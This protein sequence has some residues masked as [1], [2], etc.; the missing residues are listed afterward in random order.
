LGDLVEEV[1]AE[2]SAEAVAS[3]ERRL[4][5]VSC[6]DRVDAL[7]KV[8]RVY[9]RVTGQGVDALYSNVWVG[10]EVLGGRRLANQVPGDVRVHPIDFDR[11]EEAMGGSWDLLLT[12][13]SVQMRANDVGRLVETVRGGGLVVMAIPPVE[14]WLRTLTDFQRRLASPPYRESDVRN[15]FKRRFLET[16]RRAE[17]ARFVDLSSGSVEGRPRGAV[18]RELERPE[19][20][21][22]VLA[23]ALTPEQVEVVKAIDRL[24]RVSGRAALLVVANRGRG[25]SAALGLGIA[26]LMARRGVRGVA[27]TAPTLPTVQT[28]FKFVSRGLEALGIRGREV[29]RDGEVVAVTARGRSAFYLTPLSLVDSNVRVK[30]VD[31]AAGIP[32][33]LLFR[34]LGSSRLAIFSSTIHGYEGAGRG[35]SQRFMSRLESLQGVA[36]ERVEMRTPIRYPEGDPVERWLYDFLLLDAEP[37]DPPEDASPEAGR[38]VRVDLPSADEGFLRKFYGIYVLAHYR[39]RPNDLATLLD[40]PHHSARALLIDGEP[41]VSIQICEEG[42]LS[43]RYVEGILRR[44][45][46]PPGHM[47]P[48]RLLAHYGHKGFPKLWGWRVVRIATHPA[49]QGRG[50]GTRALRSLI[51][52]AEEAG[53]DWVGAGFGVSEELLRFW[54]R[55]GFVPVHIS[56]QRNPVSGEYSVFVVLPISRQARDMVREILGEFKRRLL[57]SLHDVY[58]DL[59]PWVARMLLSPSWG[60]ARPRLRFSQKLRLRDYLAGYNTYEM[61]SD[62]VWEIVRSYFLSP[63]KVRPLSAEEEAAL[64]ARVLQGRGW[65]MVAGLLRVKKVVEVVD[66]VRRA[67]KKLVIHYGKEKVA[68]V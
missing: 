26:H 62:A 9:R 1:A 38:Y 33:H 63:P 54:V 4:L 48:S 12:D 44:T 36:V 11:S 59:S 10:D 67:V 6:E 14:E 19:S 16:V 25:K 40:A 64:L 46:N 61:A 32:T 68:E 34:V 18:R 66:I 60:G 55:A 53:V 29:V 45:E 28:L 23:L 41:V 35:F 20:E 8:A 58:F 15:E 2:L 3:G 51:S 5:L 47:I 24:S 7:A 49:L 21:D 22:P 39:N 27:V 42:R 57:N 31:E 52:E 56:P 17:G 50:L 43:R 13:F 30:V 37:G 65:G